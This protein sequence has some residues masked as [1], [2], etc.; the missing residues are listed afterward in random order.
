MPKWR[1]PLIGSIAGRRGE[2]TSTYCTY[3]DHRYLPRGLALADSLMRHAPSSTLWVLCLNDACEQA[4]RRLGVPNI[5]I[6]TL[7]ELE[8]FDP[9]LSATKQ[10]RSLVEYYFTCSPCLP[11]FVLHL[12]RT[13]DSICYVDSDLYFFASPDLMNEELSGYSVGL[14]PHRFTPV[15]EK[16]HGR[17]GQHNVGLTYFR[18]DEDGLACLEWWREQCIQWCRDVVEGDRYADQGYLDQFSKRFPGVRSLMHPGVNLAPWNIGSVLVS[19][20]AAGPRANGQPVIFFHFQGFRLLGNRRADSNLT[21]YGSRL[22]VAAR[23]LLFVPYAR[24]LVHFQ[25]VLASLEILLPDQGSI[26]RSGQGVLG[27]LRRV[28]TATRTLVASLRGNVFKY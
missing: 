25:D 11:R 7:P 26:R 15:A 3:F 6:L 13:A 27:F 19:G 24:Q 8:A 28:S 10:T 1:Q 12:D 22:S 14:T 17:F 4:L 21:S 2:M 20:D 23:D 5:R 9:A 18:R 16:S